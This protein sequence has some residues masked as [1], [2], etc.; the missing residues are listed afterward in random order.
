[1]SAIL[2]NPTD[3]K[4]RAEIASLLAETAKTL[5]EVRKV[6]AETTKLQTESKWHPVMVAAGLL[7]AGAA[8]SGALIAILKLFVH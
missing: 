2:D 4:L 8:A 1:M 5:Q 3:E 7:G 6:S